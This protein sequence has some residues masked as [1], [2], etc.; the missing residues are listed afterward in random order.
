MGRIQGLLD[1]LGVTLDERH[2]DQPVAL[3]HAE[4]RR[5]QRQVGAGADRQVD[6]GRFGRRGTP[7][8]DD[9]DLRAGALAISDPRPH[10]RVTGGGVAAHDQ[11]AV[12]PIDIGIGGRW[13]V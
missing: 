7:R 8:I 9:D 3:E 12:G 2:V 10:D 13:P 11:H 4:H 5:Q 6:V 1:A